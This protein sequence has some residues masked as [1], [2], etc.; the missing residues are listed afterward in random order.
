MTGDSLL[1]TITDR[2]MEGENTRSK[3]R[4]VSLDPMNQQSYSKLQERAGQYDKWRHWTYK[5]A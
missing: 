4:M 3:L 2:R 1:R 5:T